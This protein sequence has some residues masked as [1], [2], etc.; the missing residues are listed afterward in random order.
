MHVRICKAILIGM[1]VSISAS[2]SAGPANTE[3]KMAANRK[4]KS[5]KT[6]NKTATQ[7]EPVSAITIAKDGKTGCILMVPTMHANPPLTSEEQAPP[8]LW[9]SKSMSWSGECINGKANGTGVARMI[10]G[11]KVIGAW[12]G[13]VSQGQFDMGVI[14]DSNSFDTAEYKNAAL[15]SLDRSD[16]NIARSDQAQ[17]FA[18]KGLNEFITTLETAGNEASAQYYREILETIESLNEGE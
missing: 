16:S 17:S 11:G 4:A 6:V 10:S 1:A 13:N 18:K 12:Y 2:C 15:I 14:E 9:G 3:T 5:D 8:T 7:N